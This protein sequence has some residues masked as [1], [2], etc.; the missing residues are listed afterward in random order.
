MLLSLIDDWQLQPG[1]CL[2]VGDQPTDVDAATAAGMRS[3]TFHGGNLRDFV[4]P[5]LV[6]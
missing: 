3:A 1:R 4:A 2:M 5:L 6:G